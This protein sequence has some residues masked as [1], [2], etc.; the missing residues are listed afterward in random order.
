MKQTIFETRQRAEELLQ[1]AI[2]IWRKSDYSD[3]LEGIEKDPVFSLLLTALAYQANETE[4]DI[5]Q[6]KAEVL[7]EYANSLI[8]F[9]LGHAIPATAIIETGIQGDALDLELNANH[10]FT[11]GD[12]NIGFVPL[13]NT[14]VFN[15]S[16]RSIV[17]MDGRRWK[18]SLVFTSPVSDLSGLTFTIQNHNFKDLRVSIKGQPL[19]L[20]SPWDYSELPLSPCFAIDTILYNK[21][22]TYMASSLSMDL[23]VRQNVRMYCVKKQHGKKLIPFE[24]ENID[25]VFEFTGINDKFMFD[26][27]SFFLNTVI[28]VNAKQ[29]TTTL[30]AA[31]PIVRVTGYNHQGNE[32][33]DNEQQFLHLIRPSEEQMFNQMKVEV[34]R[35]STDRFNQG[36]LAKMLND[37]IN[38]YYS[39]Y[40]AF[41]HVG[42]VANDKV[43]QGLVGILSRILEATKTRSTNSN[44]GVY[45]MLRATEEEQ[46]QQASVEMS[47]ITTLGASV[48]NLLNN[49]S[50]FVP[51]IGFNAKATKQIAEPVP[52]FDEI[53]DERALASLSRYYMVTN[54][55]IV[56]PADIKVFCYHELLSRYGIVRDMIKSLTVSRRQQFDYRQCGYEIFVE[57]ILVENSFIKRGFADKLEA[58]ERLLKSMITVRCTNIYPIEVSIVIEPENN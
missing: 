4:N 26:K 54:D 34:R 39:D 40:Y 6:M 15:A 36:S 33:T 32:K 28:L 49:D 8:P 24:A 17:R 5:E 43:I 10:V 20:V 7:Q 11:L 21:S 2:E 44:P 58:S 47:Y 37:L 27:N 25:L 53:Q 56:T 57:I 22:Q 23:Y 51:P 13:L 52:G 19:P 30:S 3:N 18:V 35:L 1:K 12:T 48:N 55:R 42:D 31:N 16:V 29:Q 45:L 46:N 41:L 9:E 14:R 50:I 38:K